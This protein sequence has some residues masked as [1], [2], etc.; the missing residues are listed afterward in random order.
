MASSNYQKLSVPTEPS[1][2]AWIRRRTVQ[3]R[4]KDHLYL[5]SILCTLLLEEDSTQYSAQMLVS[6]WK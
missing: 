1:W 5:V 6:L 2:Q 4:R 3:E